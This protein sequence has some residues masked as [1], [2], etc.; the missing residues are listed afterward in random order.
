MHR[1]CLFCFSSSP[2]LLSG[3]P[4]WNRQVLQK[5][6]GIKVSESQISRADPFRADL[7]IVTLS[8]LGMI[9]KQPVVGKL[10]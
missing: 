5:S 10:S 1:R 6:V 9:L 7:I 2:D 4:Y 3:I 8:Q